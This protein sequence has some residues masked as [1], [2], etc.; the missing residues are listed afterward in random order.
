MCRAV[1]GHVRSRNRTCALLAHSLAVGSL[2]TDTAR[3]ARTLY[4]AGPA[5]GSSLK[6]LLRRPLTTLITGRCAAPPFVFTI[7]S[8]ECP[9][10]KTTAWNW[11]DRAVLMHIRGTQRHCNVYRPIV[12]NEFYN[13]QNE[14][15]TTLQ[16]PPIR[17]APSM[18]GL[19]LCIEHQST[20]YGF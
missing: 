2:M 10:E 19:P 7:R 12:C 16:K 17:V 15:T 5:S 18:R 11:V 3:F 13:Y 6:P 9:P 1:V 14:A 20:L 4:N 8:S